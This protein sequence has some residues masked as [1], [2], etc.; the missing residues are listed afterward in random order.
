MKVFEIITEHC[1]TNEE[2]V[3][4]HRYVTSEQNTIKSVADYFTQHCLEYDKKLIGIREIL[5]I[6]QHITA[7]ETQNEPV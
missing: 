1:G 6:V 4:E 2:I 7:T 5:I 3:T